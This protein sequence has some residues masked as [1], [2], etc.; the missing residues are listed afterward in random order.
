[1]SDA[2]SRI[3]YV[4]DKDCCQMIE[5][6]L[7]VEEPD[8]EFVGASSADEALN[9]IEKGKFNLFV[10]EY[11]LPGTSGIEL[12]RRIRQADRETPILFYSGMARLA[13][14]DVAIA[15][16]ATEYLVKPNDLD[17]L[18]RTM[19][20]LLNKNLLFSESENAHKVYQDIY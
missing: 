7:N 19:K 10:L 16:G 17:K 15:A 6:M 9:L 14:R 8:Y 13:D 5:L 11:F 12:C 3:L 1:M 18:I 20:S 4:D 2:K